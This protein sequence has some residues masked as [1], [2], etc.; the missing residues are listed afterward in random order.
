M[1]TAQFKLTDG[2][3]G[4]RVS[5]EPLGA[6]LINPLSISLYVPVSYNFTLANKVFITEFDKKPHSVKYQHMI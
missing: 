4:F 2:R 1:F 5:L 3:K 6:S